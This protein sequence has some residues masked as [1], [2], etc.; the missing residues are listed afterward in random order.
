MF[1]N[2]YIVPT[3]QNSFT[4][5]Y[6]IDFAYMPTMISKDFILNEKD[7]NAFLVEKGSQEEFIQDQKTESPYQLAKKYKRVNGWRL[8]RIKDILSKGYISNDEAFEI[9][10]EKGAGEFIEQA[11]KF[12]INLPI[13][14]DERASAIK[15]YED[16]IEYTKK[17]VIAKTEKLIENSNEI[18][19]GEKERFK[20]ELQR[21]ISQLNVKIALTNTQTQKEP[22]RATTDY[23]LIGHTQNEIKFVNQGNLDNFYENK[24]FQIMNK[25]ILIHEL[26]HK[27]GSLFKN[28]FGES[29]A[30]RLQSECLREENLY[31]DLKSIRD[32]YKELK[33]EKE[34]RKQNAEKEKQLNFISSPDEL[35]NKFGAIKEHISK[36][37]QSYADKLW[38]REVLLSGNRENTQ[39]NPYEYSEVYLDRELSLQE[40]FDYNVKYNEEYVHGEQLSVMDVM[41]IKNYCEQD[42]YTKEEKLKIITDY[43]HSKSTKSLISRKIKE[44]LIKDYNFKI[45]EFEQAEINY[46][47]ELLNKSLK[48]FI[49]DSKNIS[50]EE[51]NY[52]YIR[53]EAKLG[54]VINKT[55]KYL[56]QKR[57]KEAI[58]KYYEITQEQMKKSNMLKTF[59]T[60]SLKNPQERLKD[61]YSMSDEIITYLQAKESYLQELMDKNT[62]ARKEQDAIARQKKQETQEKERVISAKDEIKDF[63]IVIQA[64]EEQNMYFLYNYSLGKFELINV[65]ENGIEE[66]TPYQIVLKPGEAER[67]MQIWKN[68]P[69]QITQEKFKAL[70]IEPGKLETEI[71]VK[72]MQ[73]AE[74]AI[75]RKIQEQIYKFNKLKNDCPIQERKEIAN[76]VEEL[77]AKFKENSPK[78]ASDFIKNNK[79]KL[80]IIEHFLKM[81][82]T[83]QDGTIQKNK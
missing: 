64:K 70:V 71:L 16:E 9:L 29:F 25:G 80:K 7:K 6:K 42:L 10:Y 63:K 54:A 75:E 21:N 18:K 81:K 14:E 52:D 23:V 5:N 82:T 77:K 66:K 72:N 28:L 65:K 30:V 17:I 8:G 40:I 74:D 39:T 69:H 13:S 31:L 46:N 55:T 53:M 11:E 61:R 19:E 59:F 38:L 34:K 56:D 76:R 50:Y 58:D 62:K 26:G 57:T 2:Y 22:S 37:E 41:G 36:I 32:F 27:V 44:E 15:Y 83:K 73:K 1:K 33:A 47:D 35:V 20:E 60:Y 49:Y 45:E 43:L 51:D 24:N 4:L 68:A 12:M 67:I 78:K 79:T 48:N 3:S